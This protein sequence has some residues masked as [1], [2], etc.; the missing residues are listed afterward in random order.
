[1][2][3]KKAKM[4]G[5]TVA[6]SAM[7]LFGSGFS[8]YA[9]TPD[10]IDTT[11][12]A[13]TQTEAP[14]D[15]TTETTSNGSA[16]GA[17]ETSASDGRVS[18]ES[19][20]GV[21]KPTGNMTLQDNVT[22]TDAENMDF[23]TVTSKDGHTFYIVIDHNSTNDNVYFLNQVDETDLMAL[24]SAEEKA[25]FEKEETEKVEEVVK[26]T[27]NTESEVFTSKETAET[28]PTT[29]TETPRVNANLVL[30]TV[31]AIVGLLCIGG[32]YFLKMK[33]KKGGSTLDED[34]K[35]YDDE[36]YE[37]EDEEEPEFETEMVNIADL[38]DREADGSDDAN[39]EKGEM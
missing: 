7:L 3:F 28:K 18:G 38:P 27:V 35:F 20:N 32:Y 21:L 8:A 5:L 16:E 4:A 25:S 1:M 19:E 31:F 22:G 10:N 36:E 9:Y 6:L 14:S 17:T 23:M 37:N 30:A 2:A 26:P 24:M 33:P 39:N 13:E 15:T 34:L 11:G 29:E 12:T